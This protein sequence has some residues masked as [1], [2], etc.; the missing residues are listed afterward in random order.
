[1]G[2][3]HSESV[4][5]LSNRHLSFDAM[6]KPSILSKSAA[7]RFTCCWDAIAFST[8]RG[9]F[10]RSRSITKRFL[11]KRTMMPRRCKLAIRRAAVGRGSPAYCA[12][13]VGFMGLPSAWPTNSAAT[14]IRSADADAVISSSSSTQT[15]ARISSIANLATSKRRLASL[16]SCDMGRPPLARHPRTEISPESKI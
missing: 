7:A 5:I 11:P 1:M 13:L 3:P 16:I 6:A 9:E 15:H 2:A 4:S 10:T 8:T 14:S 12:A